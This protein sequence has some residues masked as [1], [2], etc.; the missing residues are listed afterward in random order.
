V[1]SYRVSD[2]N[3]YVVVTG[4]GIEDVRIVKKAFVMPFQRANVISISPFDFEITLQAM[5]IEKLNFSLPA[6]FT[7]GP[8]RG[9]SLWPELANFIRT[10][11]QSR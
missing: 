8:V 3:S 11:T 6:V 1:R 10:T 7:I 5:T 2:A 9:V 4:A